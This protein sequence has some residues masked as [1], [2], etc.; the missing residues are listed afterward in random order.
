MVL[1]YTRSPD[2]RK[3]VREASQEGV[4]PQNLAEYFGYGLIVGKKSSKE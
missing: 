1:L 3:F 2:Y 4:M